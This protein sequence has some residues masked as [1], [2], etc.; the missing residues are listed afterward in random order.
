MLKKI[1]NWTFCLRT[2]EAGGEREPREERE[3]EGGPPKSAWR[4]GKFHFSILLLIKRFILT[5][6]LYQ[7]DKT[8]Q[9]FQV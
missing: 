7:F 2:A 1:W 9:K 8:S 6:F 5:Q 3:K 4:P